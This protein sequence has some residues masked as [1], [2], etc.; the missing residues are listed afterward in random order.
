MQ[1]THGPH[2]GFQAFNSAAPSIR[3]RREQRRREREGTRSKLT[4]ARGR[5]EWTISPC[6][7]PITSP[8]GIPS[9]MLHMP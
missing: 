4:G 2:L 7:R 8:R 9:Y 6:A 3:H 1:D 5:A